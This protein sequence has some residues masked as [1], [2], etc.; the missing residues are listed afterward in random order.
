[1]AILHAVNS[2]STA[3]QVAKRVTVTGYLGHALRNFLQDSY[4]YVAIPTLDIADDLF[5]YKNTCWYFVRILSLFPMVQPVIRHLTV[6]ASP[7]RA[8]SKVYRATNM[9]PI[10]RAAK[11]Q[12]QTRRDG[13]TK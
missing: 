11:N 8:S 10:W 9:Q 4:Q 12:T 13:A 1:M 7:K 2:S 6:P 3:R 5:S